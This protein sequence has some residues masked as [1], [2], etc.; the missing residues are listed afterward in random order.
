MAA[1]A[2]KS[3]TVF[4]VPLKKVLPERQIVLLQDTSALFSGKRKEQDVSLLFFIANR[5]D[6]DYQVLLAGIQT[7]VFG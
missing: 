5:P 4:E 1:Q 6:R 7:I 3:K 2:L